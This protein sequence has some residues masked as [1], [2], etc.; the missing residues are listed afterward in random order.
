MNKENFKETIEL[1]INDKNL[2]KNF[3]SCKHTKQTRLFGF[4]TTNIRNI[5]SI[6]YYIKELVPKYL[7]FEK[8]NNFKGWS[9]YCKNNL[10]RDKQKYKRLELA[11]ILFRNVFIEDDKNY[12]KNSNINKNAKIFYNILEDYNENILELFLS[13]YLLD[14]KY[15]DIEKQPLNDIERI[16]N[17]YNGDLEQDCIDYIKNNKKNKLFF[18]LLFFNKTD[19]LFEDVFYFLIENNEKYIKNELDYLRYIFEKEN[20]IFK[21]KILNAGGEKNF[22]HDAFIVL[23]YL[24]FKNISKNNYNEFLLN[25]TET[26]RII[27]DQYVEKIFSYNLNKFLNID[28]KYKEDIKSL[29]YKYKD[30]IYSVF[31]FSLN[32]TEEEEIK[33]LNCKRKQNIKFEAMDRYNYKCFMHICGCD[34][35]W[36][37]KSYFKNKHNKI[38]LEG[39]HVIQIENSKLFEKSLDVIENIIPLCPNCHRKIHNAENKIVGEMLKIIYNKLDKKALM[40]KGIFTDLNTLASFYGLEDIDNG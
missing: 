31:F 21:N 27:I 6:V 14:G 12:Y 30:L 13:F 7:E 2:N 22:K 24:I 37:E 33:V 3:I 38:F 4:I 29:L 17:L 16:I 1:I 20:N 19:K 8:E 35:E 28:Y 26:T 15:F 11:K 32:L 9:D 34:E 10:I 5:G 25:K 40:K 23:N 39:H 18:S 36:H